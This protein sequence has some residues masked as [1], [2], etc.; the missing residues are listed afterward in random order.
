MVCHESLEEYYKINFILKQQGYSLEELDFMI[1]WERD[2]YV[3]MVTNWLEEEAERIKN[4][5]N[6]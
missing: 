2:V 4:L 6:Q 1:P 3:S 5:K